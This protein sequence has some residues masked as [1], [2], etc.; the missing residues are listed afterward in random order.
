VTNSRGQFDLEDPSLP[1]WIERGALRSGGFPY[2]NRLSRKKANAALY[3]LRKQLV[4]LQSHLLHSGERVLILF[5]GNDAAGKGGAVATYREHLN[6]RNTIGVALPK[7]SDREQGE[8]YFQRYVEQLPSRGETVLFDRSW[9]NRAGV[10]SVLGFA[11]AEQV[12]KFIEEVPRFERML[13]NDGIHLFKFWLSIG[14]EM[15]LKRFH[16]RKHN[17]L[18]VWKLSPVDLKAL[19]KWDEYLAAAKRMLP[20]T[21]TAHA[22]WTIVRDNDKRRG[23]LDIIRSVLL[24]LDYRGKDEELIGA[25]DPLITLS[26]EDFVRELPEN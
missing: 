10:E 19:G 9:Y 7:P 11:T 15:Q 23:R 14:R 16:K 8:W 12:E 25:I 18:K 6:P 4:V 1:E 20:A 13:V 2:D 3:E 22:P 24:K 17:P 21:D 26:A 5:E